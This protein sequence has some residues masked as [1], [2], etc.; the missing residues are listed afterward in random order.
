VLV[1]FAGGALMN[2]AQSSM[3]ALAA[4][5]YPTQGRATGVAWMLGIGGFGGIAGSFLIAE[6]ARRQLDFASIFAIVAVAGV[7]AALALAIKQFAHPESAQATGSA[8]DE[9]GKHAHS[10]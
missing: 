9:G 5:F 8:I 3:P 1:V 10:H 2:T 6:L 4:G 7:I